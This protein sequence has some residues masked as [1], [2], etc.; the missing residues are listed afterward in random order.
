MK[1][2]HKKKTQRVGFTVYHV[3]FLIG[4]FGIV[5]FYLFSLSKTSLTQSIPK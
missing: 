1:Q 2:T 3:A 5:L 4:I